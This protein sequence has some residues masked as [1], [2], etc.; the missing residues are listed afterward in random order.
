MGVVLD[1]SR[2]GPADL[3]NCIAGQ[4]N[5][6]NGQICI[7]G[8][9]CEDLVKNYTQLH[10]NVGFQPRHDSVDDRLTVYQHLVLFAG[11]AGVP[12]ADCDKHAKK[13]I[14]SLLLEDKT[15]E[16]AED[17]THGQLR[18]LTLGMA[19]IGRP[20][21]VVLS[22]PLEGVDPHTKNKMIETIIKYTKGRA[23]L[24]SSQDPVVTSR[25]A[26]RVAIMDEGKF[27]AIGSVSHI[28]QTHSSGF[29]LEIQADKKKLKLQRP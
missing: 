21:L 6:I 29:T 13:M 15:N 27:V 14:K 2:A 18:R 7:N 11:I 5:P 17:L 19:L 24:M 28:L 16:P 9:I 22:C 20:K 25:I 23:L 8:S 12:K 4:K 3:L 1:A 26:D 10:G